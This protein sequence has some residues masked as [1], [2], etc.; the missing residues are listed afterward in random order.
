MRKKRH[1]RL[2][3]SNTD[4]RHFYIA[5]Y[6]VCIYTDAATNE[7]LFEVNSDNPIN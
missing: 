3:T 1:K 2:R 4:Y 6:L 7:H 5:S